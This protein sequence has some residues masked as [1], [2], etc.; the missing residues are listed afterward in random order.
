MSVPATPAVP[1]FDH[2]FVIIMENHSF[3]QIIGSADSTPDFGWITPNMLD[4]MHDGTVAQGDTW[5]SQNVPA[6]LSSPAF[7]T[8]RSL[9]FI[10]WDENDGSSGNR[11]PTIVVSPYTAPGTR[12][13]TGFSHYS[14]LRTA[15]ELLAIPTHLER[16]ATAPSMRTAFGL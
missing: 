15:E 7:T 3:S 1:G 4:D 6:L 8:Q 16:A 9:L 5:L 12:S 10:T 2:I 11:V 13:S 14:L